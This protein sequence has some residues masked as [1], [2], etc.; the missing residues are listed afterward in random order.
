MRLSAHIKQSYSLLDFNLHTQLPYLMLQAK[1]RYGYCHLSF[2]AHPHKSIH[3]RSIFH[4]R[5]IRLFWFEGTMVITLLYGIFQLNRFVWF[6]HRV[7][8]Q[9]LQSLFL[10]HPTSK[11]PTVQHHYST[12]ANWT[13]TSSKSLIDVGYINLAAMK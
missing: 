12:L 3:P 8:A 4:E 1:L 10:S 6:H 9:L 7:F 11:L 13:M 2:S 5:A